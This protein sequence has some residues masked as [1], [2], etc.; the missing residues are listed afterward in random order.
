MTTSKNKVYF[1][2]ITIILNE[3][4]YPEN[5]GASARS[6]KNMGLF[7]LRIVNPRIWDEEKIFKMA[8]HEALDVIEA[9][10]RFTNLRD[11]VSDLHFLV[12]TTARTG[13]KRRP[14]HTPRTLAKKII[15]FQKDL[16]IGILFGSEKWGLDNNAIN[17]CNEIVTI[18][19]ANFSSIN[20]AQSVMIIC[21][22]LFMARINEKDLIFHPKLATIREREGMFQHILEVSKA[23]GLFE[24]Q[25]PEYWMTNAR[26][27]FNRKEL[28][29]RDV[30]MVRGF[31]RQILWA[32]KNAR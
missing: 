4:R 26:I 9:S 32:L 8:T 3:P 10:T 21:Y 11:A 25:T 2:N 16:K 14:T 28:S 13:R 6:L 27:F 23:I 18:P 22:E 30:K 29:S 24:K 5:I 1:P 15:T 17:L 7:N 20:L 19:T 31:L 12:G